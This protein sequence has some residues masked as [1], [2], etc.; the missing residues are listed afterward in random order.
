MEKFALLSVYEKT[1]IADLASSLTKLGYKIISTGGTARELESKKIPVIDVSDLTGFPELFD[2]RVKTLHPKIHGGVL[3]RRELKKDSSEAE[4]HGIKNIEVVVVNFYPFEKGLERNLSRE[5]MIELIDV[6]GPA[7]MRAAAKNYKNVFVISSPSQYREFIERMKEGRVDEEYRLALALEAWNVVSHYDVLI[8]KYF[9]EMVNR[10]GYPRH[11]NLTFEKRLELRYGENPHQSAALYADMHYKNSSIPFAEQLQGK[12]LSYNNIL[13]ADS[14]L[15]V[16][17]EFDEPTAVI[18]KHNNPCGVA[19]SDDIVEAFRVARSV[20]PEAAFGGVIGINRKVDEK[21]AKEVTS[22]FAE[23]VVAPDYSEEAL[24]IFS[25][26]KNLRLLKLPIHKSRPHRTYRSVE[27]GILAQD[28]DEI[29]F[30]NFDVTTK[31]KPTDEEKKA[32]LYAWK[33][34]KHVKSNA[35]VYAKSNRAVGIGAGQMKRIDAAKLGAMIAKDFG[36]KLEGCAM[37]SDAFFP[38]KDGVD[39]AASIGVKAII[40]PGGS[41][42]DKE[43][44]AAADEHGI[45]MVFTGTRHF[46]H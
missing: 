2:G 14:A 18:I 42:N 21:L 28:S 15:K 35:I 45:A 25:K 38:F 46:R 40:Q 4:K 44:I 32:M 10:E 1:G 30:Q 13:D 23:I 17:R 6:G 27:G 22:K 16:L 3:F 34:V 43:V 29:L 7:L 36:E 5:E 19:S 37:A 26:K 12:Q 9:S 31:R 39:Y 11:L 8:E 20:D 24:K 41:V 33:I